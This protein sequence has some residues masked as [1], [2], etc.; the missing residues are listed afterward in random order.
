MP[1]SRSDAYTPAARRVLD[2]AAELFYEQGIN[3]VGVDLIARRAGVTKKTLY[4]RFGSKDALITAYLQARDKRWRAWLAAEVERTAG[5]APPAERILAT[6]DALAAWAVKESPRGCS[7]VNAAAELPDPSH[8]ARVVIIG[9]KRWL[10]NY[11]LDLCRAAGVA[12]PAALADEL[13][14]MHEGANVMIGL[15]V[16]DDPVATVRRLAELALERAGLGATA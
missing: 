1:A 8:P 12:E 2:A 6:F 5:A 7:L 4:D 13:A 16:L 11:L 9:Q 15:G 10:R 14:L 3:A